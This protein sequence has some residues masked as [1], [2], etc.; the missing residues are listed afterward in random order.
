M[1]AM[2]VIGA[3]A[4]RG[5]NRE[6]ARLLRTYCFVDQPAESDDNYCASRS[7]RFARLQK[8]GNR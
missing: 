3:Y 5:D 8:G 6:L 1:L 2:A 4:R 7:R